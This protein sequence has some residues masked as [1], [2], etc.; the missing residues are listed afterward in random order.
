M[1]G[2][3]YDLMW[4]LHI[5]IWGF[6][7]LLWPLTY[8]SIQLFI[9]FYTSYWV[10]MGKWAGTC[11]AGLIE[12][13]FLISFHDGVEEEKYVT[14]IIYTIVMGGAV[15]AHWFY[16]DKLLDFYARYDYDQSTL[17]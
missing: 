13:L 6:M 14:V 11:L 7:L 2:I 9:D 17:S 10:Y 16:L 3:T 15:F 4:P 8:L 12:L 1:F 5:I